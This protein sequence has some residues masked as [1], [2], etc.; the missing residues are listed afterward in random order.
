M[1]S[2]EIF[3]SCLAAI[4]LIVSL[5][6]LSLLVYSYLDSWE[7][8][9]DFREK[10]FYNSFMFIMAVIWGPITVGVIIAAQ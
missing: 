4:W 8:R 3:L 2:V 10:P 7:M 9:Q 5:G 6:I 1:F